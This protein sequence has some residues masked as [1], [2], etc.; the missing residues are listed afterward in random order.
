MAKIE[1]AENMFAGMLPERW[2]AAL[3]GDAV[4]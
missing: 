3:A 2:S 1:K 4:I